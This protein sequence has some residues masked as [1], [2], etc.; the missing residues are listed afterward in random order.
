VPRIMK[1]DGPRQASASN[2]TIVWA[3]APSNRK[4]PY[5]PELECQWYLP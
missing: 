4:K 3:Q 1:C 5:A 2:W